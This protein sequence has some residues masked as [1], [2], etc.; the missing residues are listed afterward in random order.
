VHVVPLGFWRYGLNYIKRQD[1]KGRDYYWSANDSVPER[2]EHATDINTL[3]LGHVTI[4]PLQF[5][6][7]KSRMLKSME[8]WSLSL[9]T[10]A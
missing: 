3:A 2:T 6:L 9:A 7:T 8:N 1:P 5:D 4:T 10:D